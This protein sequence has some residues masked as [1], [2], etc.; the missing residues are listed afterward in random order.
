MDKEPREIPTNYDDDVD[1]NPFLDI[2]ALLL[3]DYKQH[4][5]DRVPPSVLAAAISG[6]GIYTWRFSETVL[7]DEAGEADAHYALNRQYEWEVDP[8]SSQ[9]ADP[10]SPAEVWGDDPE[11]A[12]SRFGWAKEVVPDEL[13]RYLD[14]VRQDPDTQQLWREFTKPRIAIDRH[15][16]MWNATATPTARDRAEKDAGVAA[17]L[18]ERADL[19]KKATHAGD[20]AEEGR[21]RKPEGY[22]NYDQDLQNRANE[23]AAK[24]MET[25]RRKITKNA[26]AKILAKQRDMDEATVLRRIR[27]E[28]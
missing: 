9:R 13:V 22:L 12:Y 19:E 20:E 24:A 27:K 14:N 4:V 6:C 25:N 17:L 11:N 23:I 1:D 5:K 8:L 28:W 16:A 21:K 7:A 26:A 10:R 15:L 18:K 2:G 3:G